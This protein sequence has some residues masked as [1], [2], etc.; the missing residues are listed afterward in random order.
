MLVGAINVPGGNAKG[1]G[2]VVFGSR[3]PFSASLSLGSLTGINGFNV[4]G[5]NIGDQA[6]RSISS[7]DINGDG[8]ADLLIGLLAPQRAFI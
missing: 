6:G 3:Q 5:I 8:I 7:G 4:I 1:A 2:Y